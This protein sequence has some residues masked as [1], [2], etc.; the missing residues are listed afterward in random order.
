MLLIAGAA[1]AMATGAFAQS[2]YGD[3]AG[4]TKAAYLASIKATFEKGDVN[5]DGKL[6][7]GEQAATEGDNEVRR[8]EIAAMGENHVVLTLDTLLSGSAEM[9]DEMD[10][11]KDGLLSREESAARWRQ[12]NDMLAD[13]KVDKA[14]RLAQ[15][16]AQFERL[17]TDKDG[18]VGRLTLDEALAASA[19]RFE[20]SDTNKDGFIT[21]DEATAANLAAIA[22]R[23]GQQTP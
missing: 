14:E 21:M 11:N 20:A 7:L 6:T 15:T 22:Q 18:K 3:D 8:A 5:K 13:G 1:C 2:R 12:V 19:A 23:A 10:T 4:R 9:F 16:R 17:D